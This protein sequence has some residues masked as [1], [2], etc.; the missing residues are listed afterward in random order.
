MSF[1]C[2][3]LCRG[4]VA[5]VLQHIRIWQIKL[6]LHC[7][8]L[9]VLDERFI[10]NELVFKKYQARYITVRINQLR[11]GLRVSEQLTTSTE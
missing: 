8:C 10:S 11:G 6:V 1:V 5:G 4:R 9:F 7:A 3:P 2:R